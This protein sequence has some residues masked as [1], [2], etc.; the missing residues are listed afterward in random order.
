MSPKKK[1]TV[2]EKIRKK[3]AMQRKAERTGMSHYDFISE[4]QSAEDRGEESERQ[5]QSI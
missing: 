2:A 1:M 5:N 3:A 4:V